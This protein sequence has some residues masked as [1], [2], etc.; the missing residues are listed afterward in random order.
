MESASRR[1]YLLRAI[2]EWALDNHLTPHLLVAA[3][4][5]DVVV[6]T[7]FVQDGRIVLNIAPEAVSGFD[8]GTD[9]LFFSAR[10]GG[11]SR[12]IEVPVRAVLA[13]YARENGEGIDL[14][15]PEPATPSPDGSNKT[16]PGDSHDG[17]K[18]ASTGRGK[19]KLHVVK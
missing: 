8:P 17:N 13:V 9:P 2:Y 15:P 18:P 1:P 11:R 19:P 16:G 6:P 5:P 12:E 3:D 7:G 4:E 14:G 10:F